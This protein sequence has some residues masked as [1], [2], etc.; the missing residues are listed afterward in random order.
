MWKGYI[1]LS[2]VHS[3]LLGV[4]AGNKIHF[5]KAC[6]SEANNIT[7]R[8]LFPTI[9]VIIGNREMEGMGVQ[10]SFILQ[11]ETVGQTQTND[12]DG[13]IQFPAIHWLAPYNA[14]NIICTVFKVHSVICRGI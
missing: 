11:F 3:V 8:Y 1:V 7:N 9:Y 10:M 13:R 5:C 14:Q 4:R 2:A 6:I 12:K